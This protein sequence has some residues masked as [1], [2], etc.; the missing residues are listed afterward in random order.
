MVEGL[1][2]RAAGRLCRGPDLLPSYGHAVRVHSRGLGIGPWL[3]GSRRDGE[4]AIAVVMEHCSQ[5]ER[6]LAESPE[7]YAPILGMDTDSGSVFWQPWIGGFEQGMRLR[8]NGIRKGSFLC[9]SFKISADASTHV[10]S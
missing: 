9:P 2:S 3:Q 10:D 5:I 6:R 1:E 4:E 8:R 7:N